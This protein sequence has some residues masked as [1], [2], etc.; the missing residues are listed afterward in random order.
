MLLAEKYKVMCNML[1]QPAGAVNLT[2]AE[3]TLPWFFIY[4]LILRERFDMFCLFRQELGEKKIKTAATQ[5]DW[6][7]QQ[8]SLIHRLIRWNTVLFT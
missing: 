5:T 1:M 7:S 4:A 2:E 6:A 8:F 3:V